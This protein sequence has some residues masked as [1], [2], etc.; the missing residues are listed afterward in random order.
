MNERLYVKPPAAETAE[1]FSKEFALVKIPPAVVLTD[2]VPPGA[3]GGAASNDRV[4]SKWPLLP[5]ALWSVIVVPVPFQE[6]GKSYS[7]TG[8]VWACAPDAA[9]PNTAA[10]AEIGMNV[11]MAYFFIARGSFYNSRFVLNT[12]NLLLYINHGLFAR[13][14]ANFLA[15]WEEN[16]SVNELVGFGQ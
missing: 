5:A 11:L 1:L 6:A 3:A 13:K 10:T 9:S 4:P 8:V 14:N 16:V 2:A 15:G 12:D 7:N